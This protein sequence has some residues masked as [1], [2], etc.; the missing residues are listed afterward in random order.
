L[1]VLDGGITNTLPAGDL[2]LVNP[3]S[4]ALFAVGAAFTNT[5]VVR[6]AENDPLTQYLDWSGVHMRQAH[7]VA[8][9]DWARVLVEAQGGPLVFAGETGG[10]RVAVLTFDLHD[11]DLPLQVAF[12][13]LISNL[14]NY[15]APAQP[16]SAPDGLRPGESLLIKPTSGAQISVADPTGAVLAP[17]LTQAGLAFAETR[18][19]GVYTVFSGQTV[20]GYFAVNLF[21]AGESNIRPAASIQIGRIQVAPTARDAQGQLEIWPWLAAAAFL[22]LLVEWWVYHRGATLPAASGWRGLFVR[23]KPG[24]T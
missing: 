13:V 14:L 23:R 8:V 21:D 18:R 2:L 16:F 10:R 5:Q 24:A 20:I 11:S 17:T 6:V 3:P 9:P 7:Q 1:Y 4:N 15:L 22:L 12:P 19:L